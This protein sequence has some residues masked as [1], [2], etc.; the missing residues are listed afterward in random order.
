MQYRTFRSWVLLIVSVLWPSVDGMCAEEEAWRADAEKRI[1]QHRQADACVVVLD[2]AGQPFSGVEVTVEQVQHDFLFGCNIFLWGRVGNEGDEQQYRERYAGLF[3]YA[4]LPFYWPAYERQRGEPDHARTEQV[5]RWC[6][7]RGIVTKGHPLA[8]NFSDPR[9]LPDDPAAV[10]QLQYARI[11]DCVG[12]FTGLIDRWDVVNEAT[13]FERDEFRQRAPKMT[14]TW[15]D[16][17]RVEFTKACFE[18]ARKAHPQATLVIN[19]Y[20]TDA[21]FE[22]LIEQLTD[23]EG[24]RI[25]D[26]IGIQSHMHGGTWDNAHIWDVCERFA[27]FGVPLHFTETTIISGDPPRRGGGRDADWSTTSEREGWQADEVE[28]FYTML[29]SHPAVRALTWW[30]FADRNAWQGAPA[31]FLRKDLSVKPAYERLLG[32][33]KGRWWTRTTGRTKDDGNYAFR[34]FLGRYRVTVKDN[35][36]RTNSADLTLARDQVNTVEIR[37]REP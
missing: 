35:A 30:D 27:R 8:W 3:N 4:T 36:G 29:F 28:R 37:W 17:G 22:K 1:E 31:G 33:V 11:T 9:W 13:H 16:T 24:K 15:E 32:L 26:V 34:G 20:R 10:R 14:R 5:A 2:A 12:R 19:D 21:A 7:E 25:Y 23:A 18:A 6:Q